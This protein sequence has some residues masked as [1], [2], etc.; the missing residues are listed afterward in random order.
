[1]ETEDHPM[2]RYV[3]GFLIS[4]NKRLVALIEKQKPRWQKGKWNGIG[5]KIK[6]GEHEIDAMSREFHEETGVLFSPTAW[7]EITTLRGDDW[8]VT[9]FY[10]IHLHVMKVKTMTKERVAIHAPS[11]LPENVIPNL[12]WLIPLAMD[13]TVMKPLGIRGIKLTDAELGGK[14]VG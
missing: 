11:Q 10:L 3:C 13:D 12:R 4:P 6:P 2:I 14:I 9:F 1:M 7:T 5:G 8:E